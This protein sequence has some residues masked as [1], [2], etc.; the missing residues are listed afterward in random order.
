MAEQTKLLVGL[1]IHVQLQTKSKLF[2]NCSNESF[3]AEPNVNICP[4]CL[5]HPGTLPV[6]NRKAIEYILLAGLTFGSE[7]PRT[8][9]FDRKNYF[10]PDLAKG[11]QISQF[12]QPF[13]E[14]GEIEVV[15]PDSKTIR[16]QRIHLEEDAGKLVHP[17]GADYSL[18]DFNRAGTPLIE[19][20]TEP[21]IHSVDEAVALAKKIQETCRYLGISKADMEK[22]HMRFDM[23]INFVKGDER[24][25]EITE[26]KNL[27]SF[28]SLAK[29]IEFETV[30]HQEAIEAGERLV[31]ET[32]GWDDD[33]EVTLEQRS[34]EDAPDYRYF[35]EPDIPTIKI[36]Q[37]LI[38]KISRMIPEMPEDKARRFKEEYGLSA[39]DIAIIVS[40]KKTAEFF[41]DSVSECFEWA[42]SI[43]GK[44]SEEESGKKK[45]VKMISNW[46]QSELFGLMKADKKMI[47]D[48][49]INPENFAELI[50]MIYEKRI[51][52]SAGQTI[53]RE[54][55]RTGGDPSQIMSEKSL[56]QVN[57]SSE[58]E[59]ICDEVMA[60][61]PDETQ[62]VREGNKGTLQFLM[63]QVMKKTGGSANPQTAME[64]LQRKIG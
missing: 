12:D 16:L 32:R 53:L 13:C 30:R 20:V 61:H 19:I 58:L 15:A 18:V 6:P 34:K 4:I 39:E 55:Y 31:H 23:N 27:N 49:K 52:S 50:A 14:G 11:Y 64:I 36:S 47:E 35:P 25:T 22:G 2:C 40:D 33:N 45:I 1:E 41:E 8:S 10:Y 48:I 29:S 26:V 28:R 60:E 57:D 37:D 62:K 9:K 42:V 3:N 63:G 56:E 21:D 44:D 43:E 5:G 54:M 51:N 38:N 46:L 7:I 17:T 59:Q 24:L